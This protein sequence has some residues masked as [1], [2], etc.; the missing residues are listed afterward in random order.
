MRL[1]SSIFI[2]LGML[3]IP[4]A[5]LTFLA[6]IISLFTDGFEEFGKLSVI[7]FLINPIAGTIFGLLAAT[8]N[9]E[10]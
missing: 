10:E 9:P 6:A 4:A 5:G 7:A 2:G 1:I 8:F 3:T